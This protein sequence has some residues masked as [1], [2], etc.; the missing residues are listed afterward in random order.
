[1][2]LVLADR[3]FQR[4]ATFLPV[5]EQFVNGGRFENGAGQAVRT[6]FRAFFHHA[7]LD[8]LAG[9]LGHL[10]DAAGAGQSR[11]ASADDDDIELHH[12]PFHH[13]TP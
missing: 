6:Q 1:M 7:D 11:R 5:G 12:F 4:S 9:L 2:H 3:H 10:E 13:Y 8:L